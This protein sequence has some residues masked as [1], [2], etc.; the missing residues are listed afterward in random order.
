M[1]GTGAVGWAG[2]G[3]PF[4]RGQHCLQLLQGLLGHTQH[5]VSPVIT[6][7]TPPT[8]ARTPAPTGFHV[9]GSVD[10][11][12]RHHVAIGGLCQ[13]RGSRSRPFERL[14]T[15]GAC[16]GVQRQTVEGLVRSCGGG[17][18]SGAH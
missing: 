8:P 1:G 6:T 10:G 5:C 4:V 11:R 18:P 2:S 9:A 15:F 17:G 12:Q 3:R 14:P 16:G 7:Q 13:G